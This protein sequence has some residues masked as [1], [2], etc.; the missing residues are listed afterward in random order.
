MNLGILPFTRTDNTRTEPVMLKVKFWGTRGSIPSSGDDK[1]YFG[2]N[3]SCVEVRVNDQLFIFDCGT[4]LRALGNELLKELPVS[5]KIFISHLHWD[6]IQGFPFFTP[7]IL[8]GNRFE[9]YA[10]PNSKQNIKQMLTYQMQ[11]PNFPVPLSIMG[12]NLTFHDINVKDVFTFDGVTISSKKVNHPGGA[13]A[14][15]LEYDGFTM[16]YVTDNEHYSDKIDEKLLEFIQ[17]ADFVIY[18]AQYLPEEYYGLDGSPSKKGWGHSTMVHGAKLAKE[19]NIGLLALFHHDPNH[20]DEIVFG[21]E[22]EAKKHFPKTI[23][24]YDGMV[25]TKKDKEQELEISQRDLIQDKTA[26]GQNKE[27]SLRKLIE[28]SMQISGEDDLENLLKLIVEKSM[29][30]TDSDG[31]SIYL[32]E[33]ADGKDVLAF[34]ATYNQSVTVPSAF[35]LDINADS[36]AGYVAMTGNIVQID[37]AYKIS[38]S[39]PYRF[40][41]DLDK[42][43]SYKTVSMLV[44]PITNY[45]KDVIGVIQLINRKKDAQEKISI[46]SSFQDILPYDTNCEDLLKSLSVLAGGA[47]EKV[48]MIFEMK[49]AMRKVEET[50]TMLVQQEKLASLGTMAAGLA[51]ELSQPLSN[52]NLLSSL[53][54]A[55][56]K[57][58]QLSTEETEERL[59]QIEHQ[60]NRMGGLIDHLRSY[61]RKGSSTLNLQKLDVQE[62]VEATLAFIRIQIVQNNIN[63]KINKEENL[64]AVMADPIQFEQVIINIINNA[65]DS[66]LDV[67][68]EKRNLTVS[69][70]EEASNV[71]III[72][73]TGIGMTNEVKEK[74][75]TP[76]YTT[77][78]TAKGTGLGLFICYE[79]LEHHRGSIEVDSSVGNGAC[80]TVKLPTC[81]AV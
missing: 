41:S 44:L 79:I 67:D 25:L 70:K 16:I 76:F 27:N 45:K 1:V 8:P 59:Q 21:M 33:N 24:A 66:L 17:G 56:A 72:T 69:F 46:N 78:E 31:A 40:N 77:K 65:K 5:G 74:I 71:L 81:G 18:D 28:I 75:F 10:P 12:A 51:H 55:K 36:I 57:K 54:I 47:L 42:K 43:C 68:V 50:Q 15:K 26:I 11:E 60:C 14:Y 23:A 29:Y 48:M 13:F 9:L 49:E 39:M 30:L 35:K 37:N 64:P 22:E 61:S 20:S 62:V 58:Q 19:A 7:A 32:K 3:T 53:L 6:H 52:I 4:G 63:L 2:G 80:F 38:K 73:D 34:K